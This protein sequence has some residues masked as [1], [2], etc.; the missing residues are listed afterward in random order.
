MSDTTLIP[1]T[2]T[3]TSKRISFVADRPPPPIPNKPPFRGLDKMSKSKPPKTV[4]GIP[5]EQLNALR[6]GIG[7]NKTPEE[8]MAWWKKEIRE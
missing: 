7:A 3:P 6:E 5:R 1:V 8:H 2:T 4:H